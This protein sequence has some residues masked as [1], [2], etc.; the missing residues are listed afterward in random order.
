MLFGYAKAKQEPIW[1]GIDV[2]DWRQIGRYKWWLSNKGYTKRYGESQ[3]CQT[4]AGQPGYRYSRRSFNR[5]D[6]RILLS[7]LLSTKSPDVSFRPIRF[8]RQPMHRQPPI[9]SR[10]AA[11]H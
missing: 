8:S 2:T 4:R 9:G 11:F 1:I 6:P 10:P 7:E 5:S 3:G